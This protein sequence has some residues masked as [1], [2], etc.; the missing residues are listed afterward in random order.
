M[1]SLVICSSVVDK[2]VA[3]K[4]R[5]YIEWNCPSIAVHDD[6]LVP[7]GSELLEMLGR[8]L[9]ADVVL[10]LLSPD[11]VPGVWSRQEW[12]PVLLEQPRELDTALAFLLMR[13]C[14]FPEML[15]KQ[16]FFDLSGDW[17]A[18]IR[19]LRHWLLDQNPLKQERSDLLPPRPATAGVSGEL[20]FDL[21]RRI[22]DQPGTVC[23]VHRD[24]ALAFAHAYSRDFED[25]FWLDCAGRSR[26]GVIGDTAHAL[27]IKLTGSIAQNSISLREFCAGP[28][29]LFVFD[30]L[31]VE[32]RDL[33]KLEGRASV[34][35]TAGPPEQSSMLPLAQTVELFAHWQSDSARCLD[36]LRDAGQHLQI[37][38]H[39]CSQ[40]TAHA[41][42]SLAAYMFGLLR[43][44]KRLA[45]AYEILEILA[46]RAWNDGEAA[47]L[48]HWEWEKSWI[49]EAWG[50]PA[51]APLR[52]GTMAQPVQSSFEF[53]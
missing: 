42:K 44:Q 46:K 1:Q 48:R 27:G 34:I 16:R 22:V 29:C 2:P 36:H 3:I 24:T 11:A 17:R 13:P 37:L 4:I 14:R 23:D 9:S 51:S 45:E 7:C 21:E 43:H 19:K 33:V 53:G 38:E 25:T 10:L 50:Q 8:A 20:L 18:G 26:A 40:E 15:R 31:A 32:D 52:L 5:R 6:A 47:D 12:E 49:R 41:V 28:R 39:T 30:Q 35:F